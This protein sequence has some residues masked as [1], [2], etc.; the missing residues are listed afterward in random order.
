MRQTPEAVQ[1]YLAERL[2]GQAACQDD[3]RVA[4]RLY[5]QPGVDGVYPLGEGAVLDDGFSCWQAWGGA[6]GWATSRARRS[7]ARWSRSCRL[8]GAI[9]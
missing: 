9:A 6:T 4:R 2:C 1:P 5:R 7:S 8:R 3:S